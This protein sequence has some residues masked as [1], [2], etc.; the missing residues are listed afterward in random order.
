MRTHKTAPIDVTDP[1]LARLCGAAKFV[2]ITFRLF[3]FDDEEIFEDTHQQ[4]FG[5][6]AILKDTELDNSFQYRLDDQHVFEINR[7]MMVSGNTATILS[8]SWLKDHFIVIGDRKHH[9]GRFNH[10]N[11][12]NIS[13]MFGTS[14]AAALAAQQQQQKSSS[15][16]NKKCDVEEEEGG[17]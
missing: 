13:S 17:C 1:E 5:Q 6:I 11:N 10:G 2:S 7:P 3:K 14:S 8:R 4:D 9:F 12:N 16:N 15:D